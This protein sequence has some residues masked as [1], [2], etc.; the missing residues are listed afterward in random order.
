M[1]TRTLVLCAV[2]A[3]S[4][5]ARYKT[6]RSKPVIL[7]IANTTNYVVAFSKDTTSIVSFGSKTGLEGVTSEVTEGDYTRKVGASSVK[8]K[9]DADLVRAGSEG[10][11][12]AILKYYGGP[13]GSALQSMR[14][15][16]VQNPPLNPGG[17]VYSEI[18]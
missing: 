15:A 12:T 6:E 1:K 7:Q 4:G 5:C 18:P 8:T 10:A 9:G 13:A 17:T 3:G 11:A 2:L 16:P 14:S